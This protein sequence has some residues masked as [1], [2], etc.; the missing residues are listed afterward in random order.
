MSTQFKLTLLGTNSASP[1]P[2]RFTS[3]QV[4]EL[5]GQSYLIDC[6]EGTQIRM[7]QFGIKKA[8]IDQIFIS[9]LHGDHINGLIG[10]LN[11]LALNGRTTPMQIFAPVGL[12][13]LLH[14]YNSLTGGQLPYDCRF[15]NLNTEKHQLI[16]ENKQVE[17]YSIPL[18]H[19]VPAS[20]FLFREKTK[21]RS[22]IGE[23]IPLHQIPFKDIPSIKAGND[24]IDT[25][26]NLI[27][28]NELTIDP[29]LPRSFAYCSDTAYKE[30]I[31][32]IIKRVDLLYHE[33]T[34]CEDGANL[35]K[36]RGH[37]TA[38]EAATIAQKA[39][40]NQLI[41]GHYSSRYKTLEQFGQEAQ[42]I[43][44]NTLIGEDGVS[45]EVPLKKR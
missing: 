29:P 12:E 36:E 2:N 22:I 31:I 11:S 16:F 33:A 37:S 14:T 20:G 43:F 28:N 18:D 3:A 26:G 21:L 41:L 13:G 4:L 35:A 39:E 32:P 42:S 7:Q 25:E 34:Y 23:K 27:P 30:D 15:H 19:R 9:H 1:T 17:V 5:E 38:K 10:F 6:G 45:V 24:W 40:V 8:K 44:P